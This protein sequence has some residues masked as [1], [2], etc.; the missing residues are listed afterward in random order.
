MLRV[1]S[2]EPPGP[3]LEVKLPPHPDDGLEFDVETGIPEAFSDIGESSAEILKFPEMPAEIL[4]SEEEIEKEVPEEPGPRM[5]IQRK[6]TGFIKSP[7]DKEDEDKK[8][9][10]LVRGTRRPC[11]SVQ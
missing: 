7:M 5:R 3:S 2:T 10:R 8:P 11:C 6:Q 9:T 4:K 1:L